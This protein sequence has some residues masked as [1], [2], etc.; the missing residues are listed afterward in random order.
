MKKKVSSDSDSMLFVKK[1]MLSGVVCTFVAS[2]LNPIDVVKVRMQMR[3]N[4]WP[5]KRFIP[6][7]IKLVREEGWTGCTRGVQATIIR[8]ILYS[9]FRM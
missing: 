8:E 3:G 5:E 7:I 2:L 9:S 1:T 4:L 6:G